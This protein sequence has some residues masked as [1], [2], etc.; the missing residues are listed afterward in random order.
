M[1][2]PK[3]P[4]P[5]A[6]AGSTA[7]SSTADQPG[8]DDSGDV[9]MRLEKL[10]AMIDEMRTDMQM[11]QLELGNRLQASYDELSNKIQAV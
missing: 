11:L 6:P 3:R 2:S 10:D 7:T 8:E 5:A 4:K 9:D 1:A